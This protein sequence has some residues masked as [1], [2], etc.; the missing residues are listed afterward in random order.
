LA[1]I[2]LV[3]DHE[4]QHIA[5]DLAADTDQNVDVAPVHADEMDR[6][7]SRDADAISERLREE[8]PKLRR[9]RLAGGESEFGMANANATAD[10]AHVQIIIRASTRSAGAGWRRLP[11]IQR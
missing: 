10:R 9:E 7:F 2:R 4:V 5:I 3:P 1:G 6:A 8:C 11:P